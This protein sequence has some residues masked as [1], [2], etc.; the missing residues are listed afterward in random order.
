MRGAES[1]RLFILCF[2]DRNWFYSSAR[3]KLSVQPCEALNGS[4]RAD[5]SRTV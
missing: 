2:T 3:K 1:D 5:C 4:S